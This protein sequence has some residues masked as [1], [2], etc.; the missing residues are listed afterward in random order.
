MPTQVEEFV[1]V[2]DSPVTLGTTHH[3]ET[4]AKGPPLPRS[5]TPLQ[6]FEVDGPLWVW[7]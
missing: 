5:S 6:L 1:C 3:D 2:L 4:Q 7:P